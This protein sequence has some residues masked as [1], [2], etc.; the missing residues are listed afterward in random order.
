[1]VGIMALLAFLGSA[2]GGMRGKHDEPPPWYVKWLCLVVGSVGVAWTLSEAKGLCDVA[3]T[4]GKIVVS[5]WRGVEEIP[6]R[7]I[8]YVDETRFR[9]PKLIIIDLREA[10][11]LG[12]VIQFIPHGFGVPFGEHP[13]VTELNAV[14]KREARKTV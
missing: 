1:M 7:N 12:K 4:D 6:L 14:I 2:F 11:E 9:R 13:V 3:L 10:G 5:G 8:E